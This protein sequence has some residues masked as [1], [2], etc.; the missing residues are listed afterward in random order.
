MLSGATCTNK[1][2]ANEY[3]AGCGSVGPGAPSITYADPPAACRL[4]YPTHDG[5][6][7]FCCQCL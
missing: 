5:N 7:F 2:T 4:V 3:A 1:C 6:A